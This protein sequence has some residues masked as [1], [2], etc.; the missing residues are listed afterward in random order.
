MKKI[1][2][3]IGG[4][5]LMFGKI[6]KIETDYKDSTVVRAFHDNGKL[7]FEGIKIKKF[8]DGKWKHYDEKGNLVKIE[9]Y[10]FG[11]K[12]RTMEVGALK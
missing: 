8:R 6:T 10:K 3:I 9:N 12:I 7:K 11:R 1:V 5:G 4:V 2:I